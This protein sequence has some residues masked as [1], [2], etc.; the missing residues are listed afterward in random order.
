MV[1]AGEFDI[2]TSAITRGVCNSKEKSRWAGA[3]ENASL[4]F[5]ESWP[6]STLLPKGAPVTTSLH[7]SSTLGQDWL[8]P[9]PGEAQA[10]IFWIR[11][12]DALIPSPDSSV[13]IKEVEMLLTDPGWISNCRRIGFQ[14]STLP[15]GGS[16]GQFTK[17]DTDGGCRGAA[18]LVSLCLG[19]RLFVIMT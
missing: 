10:Q 7:V 15:D 4:A 6:V 19:F 12:Q 3:H 2:S 18:T 11:M 5:L 16:L 14:L 13:W 1:P 8:A 9:T 17:C